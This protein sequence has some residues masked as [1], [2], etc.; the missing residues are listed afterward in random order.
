MAMPEM[1]GDRLAKELIRIRPTICVIVCTGHS[2]RMDE[3][4]AR[5]LGIAAYAMKPL[6]K[7][8]LVNTVRKVLD[9]TK[10]SSSDP[11]HEF[12]PISNN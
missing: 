7:I 11:I 3:N 2:D 8:G 4:K 12:L 10:N 1:P 9:E 5:K 6:T